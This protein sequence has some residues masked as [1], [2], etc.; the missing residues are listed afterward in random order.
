[1]RHV[2]MDG[3]HTGKLS[4]ESVRAALRRVRGSA[5]NFVPRGIPGGRN[6]CPAQQAEMGSPWSVALLR[7]AAPPHRGAGP[8]GNLRI[9][10]HL[11]TPP[12][13]SFHAVQHTHTGS[14]EADARAPAETLQIGGPTGQRVHTVAAVKRAA[15]AG[16]ALQF[17]QDGVAVLAHGDAQGSP[18]KVSVPRQRRN[19]RLSA[20]LVH[21]LKVAAALPK[22]IVSARGAAGHVTVLHH[23]SGIAYGLFRHFLVGLAEAQIPD[24]APLR[25]VVLHLGV[26]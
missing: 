3:T 15:L 26:E 8:S 7:H 20:G 16:P 24:G 21:S 18:G 5:L 12:A 1:S 17:I 10:Y 14:V 11:R 25:N 13:G 22:G 19:A 4:A 6:F 9:T 23:V 2:R